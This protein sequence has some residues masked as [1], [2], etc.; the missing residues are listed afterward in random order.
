MNWRP[1]TSSELR[2]LRELYPVMGLDAVCDVIPERSRESI[3]VRLS[4]LKI[5]HPRT[6][7]AEQDAVIRD[8]Y[9]LGGWQAVQ[10]ALSNKSKK[11][12][13]Q[14]ASK[15]RVYVKNPTAGR[16]PAAGV[17]GGGST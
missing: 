14:R 16:W 8:L 13:Y 6:W 5:S 1:W 15:L 7:T 10:G 11:S 2:L 4:M 9:P 12:I 17:F 3:R